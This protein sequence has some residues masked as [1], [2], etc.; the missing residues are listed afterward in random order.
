[1]T[2]RPTPPLS[3]SVG[4]KK[5]WL[6]ISWQHVDHLDGAYGRKLAEIEGSYEDATFEA[7]LYVQH[8]SPVGVVQEIL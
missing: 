1:M 8:Y 7:R 2:T 4:D 5:K 3:G 6:I